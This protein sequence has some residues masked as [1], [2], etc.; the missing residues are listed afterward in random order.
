[1]VNFP[2][3]E[4]AVAILERAKSELEKIGFA[5]Q[6][7]AEEE[8]RLILKTDDGFYT[9]HSLHYMKL[10]LEA[11]KTIWPTDSEGTCK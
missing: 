10:E 11:V 9:G 8:K 4:E 2:G 6:V 1:M 5:V 7:K 3:H